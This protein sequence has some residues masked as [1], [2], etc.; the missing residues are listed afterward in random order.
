MTPQYPMNAQMEDGV[1]EL[2][3]SFYAVSDTPG[4]NEEWRDFYAKDAYLWMANDRAHGHDEILKVRHKMWELVA[5][6][7]HTVEK[8]FPASFNPGKAEFMLQGTVNYTLRTGE[9]AGADWA[10]HAT[11]KKNDA[12]EWKFEYYRVYIQR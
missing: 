10:G 6:R 5:E 7:K 4:M 9:K 8:V 3:S 2:I 1:K 12:G 11:L